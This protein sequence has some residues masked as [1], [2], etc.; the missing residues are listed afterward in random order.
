MRLLI[1]SEKTHL[2]AFSLLFLS[3]N[4]LQTFLVFPIPIWYYTFINI[5]TG[6]ICDMFLI[7]LQDLSTLGC[8]FVPNG[9]LKVTKSKTYLTGQLYF[10]GQAYS[11]HAISYKTNRPPR[12]K[13]IL[14]NNANELKKYITQCMFHNVNKI[15]TNILH[16]CFLSILRTAVTILLFVTC[17]YT[18]FRIEVYGA[19]FK[20]IAAMGL[21]LILELI[22]FVA[23]ISTRKRERGQLHE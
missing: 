4:I 21:V 23:N 15:T 19:S 12:I 22:C 20:N 13:R 18:I 9:I 6:V 16:R 3:L 1:R 8:R 10:N 7:T 14:S 17:V 5:A 11:V 2:C